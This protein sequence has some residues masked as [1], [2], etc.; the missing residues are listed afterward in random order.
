MTDK[1]DAYTPA[2]EAL[3]YEAI[4]CSPASWDKGTLRIG[5]ANQYL[6]YSLKN[7][8]SPDK[9]EISGALR[10][11]CEE[12]CVTMDEHGDGWTGATVEFFQ[13]DGSWSYDIQFE[14]PAVEP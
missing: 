5:L 6:S 14:R 2:I 13:T 9:A 10:E 8:T 4:E 3:V 1:L 7:A 11:L 12:L